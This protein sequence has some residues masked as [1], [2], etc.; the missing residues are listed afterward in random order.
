MLLDPRPQTHL[1]WRGR[2][3]LTDDPE[4][5]TRTDAF[6]RL[7]HLCGQG[8]AVNFKLAAPLAAIGLCRLAHLDQQIQTRTANATRLLAAVDGAPLAEL[9]YEAGGM[10]NY[11]LSGPA[12]HRRP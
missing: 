2:I 7:G 4:I 11:I 10:P 8:P 9:A 1:H 5:W 12:G 6:T 3:I